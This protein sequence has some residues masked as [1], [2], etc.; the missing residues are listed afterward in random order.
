M[1]EVASMLLTT[2][3]NFEIE[4]TSQFWGFM[5]NE[6][7]Y[8]FHSFHLNIVIPIPDRNKM[9]VSIVVSLE[10]TSY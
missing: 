2:V 1:I 3:S 9:F 7:I 10:L 5:F 6:L 8:S 4:Q